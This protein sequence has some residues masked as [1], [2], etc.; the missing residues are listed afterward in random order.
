[1][2]V[3]KPICC[4]A[5]SLKALPALGGCGQTDRGVQLMEQLATVSYVAMT[6]GTFQP[7]DSWGQVAT[8]DAPGYCVH[9]AGWWLG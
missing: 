9:K 8:T 2:D 7:L 6:S 1:M 4:I 5:I 3:T